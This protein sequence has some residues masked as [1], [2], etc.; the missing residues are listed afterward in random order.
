[1]TKILLGCYKISFLIF[2][3][4]VVVAVVF[5]STFQLDIYQNNIFLKW[6][7]MST[8]QNNLKTQKIY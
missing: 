4:V 2:K 7:L 3:S 8:H 1:M 6:F 5:Q